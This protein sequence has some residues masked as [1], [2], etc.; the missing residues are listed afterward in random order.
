MEGGKSFVAAVMVLLLIMPMLGS[1]TRQPLGGGADALRA[2]V[3]P[4]KQKRVGGSPWCCDK[5]DY[6]N[7]MNS[8]MCLDRTAR[9]VGCNAGCEYCICEHGRYATCICYDSLDSCPQLCSDYEPPVGNRDS[10]RGA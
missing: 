7:S 8:Y 6:V 3:D 5:C 1:S 2:L 9:E 4:G 10:R